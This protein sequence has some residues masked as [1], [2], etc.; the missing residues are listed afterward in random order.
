[1]PLQVRD[2]DNAIPLW[3]DLAG[4]Q[5]SL[6]NHSENHTFLL[7]VPGGEAFTLRVHRP[8]YQSVANI[9]SELAWLEALHRQTEL[10]IPEPVAGRNGKLLQ[11]FPN[12]GAALDAPDPPVRFAQEAWLDAQAG[13][14]AEVRPRLAAAIVGSRGHR[15]AEVVDQEFLVEAHAHEHVMQRLALRQGRIREAVAVVGLA[16]DQ[17]SLELIDAV[18]ANEALQLDGAGVEVPARHRCRCIHW[19]RPMVPLGVPSS[20]TTVKSRGPVRYRR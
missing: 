9:E 1:M 3:A 5:P 18:V 8:D 19:S 11:Q 10:S 17:P 15:R 7:S 2:L 16:V 4:A 6:I 14:H 20:R 12:V 13:E